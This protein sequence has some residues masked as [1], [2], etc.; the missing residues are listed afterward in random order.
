[1][2]MKIHFIPMFALV[3]SF[4]GFVEAQKSKAELRAEKDFDYYAFG[5]AS[6]KYQAV[7]K[8]SIAGK[9]NLAK[10]FQYKGR[11]NESAEVYKSFIETELA[12]ASDYLDYS[13]VLRTLGKYDEAKLWLEKY[14]LVHPDEIR[15]KKQMDA[16]PLL[17]EFSKDNGRHEIK[18][19]AMN[20]EMQDFGTAFFNNSVVFAS[21]REG[22]KSIRRSY[23]WNEKPFLDLYI[24][25]EKEG[26]LSQ[27]ILFQ[28]QLNRAM[29]EGP[30]AF[31]NGGSFMALTRNN[32][33]DKSED[34][35]VKLKIFFFDLVD[36]KWKNEKAFKY[37]SAAYSVGHPWLSE[38]GKTMFFASDKPGGYG[39]S[40]IYR[41]NR[42]SAGNWGEAYNLGS[43]INTEGDEMFPF[44]HQ[45]E[46]KLIFSSNGHLGLGGLDLFI[47]AIH[48]DTITGV[49]NFASPV[50]SPYDDFA[51]IINKE[52]KK[53]YFSS[54][55][56]NVKGDDDIYSF[57][58]IKPF[59]FTKKLEGK[60]LDPKG[61]I[62][63]GSEVILYDDKGNI[64]AID[65]TDEN[66]N[67]SFEVYPDRNYEL[68]AS[69]VTFQPNRITV[70][71]TGFEPVQKQDINL[72]KNPEFYLQILVKDEKTSQLLPF[73]KVKIRN[74]TNVEEE[75]YISSDQGE[76]RKELMKMQIG[77]T[78]QLELI[79]EKEG[80]P[81][82]KVTYS[83]VLVR[84]GVVTKEILL[85]KELPSIQEASFEVGADLSK[86]I[87]I[88]P[89]F[90][91]LGKWNIRTD[92]AVE[93]DKIVKI[94]NEYP[95]MIVEL[96]SHTDCRS[97]ASFN[98]T[99]SDNRAKSSAEY[100]KK[101]ISTP[102]R[103][104][105]KGYGESKLLNSC[106]CEGNIKSTCS[107]EQHQQNRRTE[108]I[109]IKN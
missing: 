29:H 97:S 81:A 52:F 16:Y 22:V 94:M 69:K 79:V 67:Y 88:K 42:D 72:N 55:R 9:R 70:N 59:V 37:N 63:A 27:P 2:K 66:G 98:K 103:I 74:K 18:L 107:E 40:D 106:A 109:I 5:N 15:A 83:E 61:A 54:N 26:E 25:E 96:G 53:G 51:L 60:S 44:Y 68:A 87:D 50:N 45:G 13:F 99:L 39:G 4:S 35:I 95:N 11:F 36:E 47:A 41:I 75:I 33:E 104:Y 58:L 80:Y 62:L 78:V 64:L 108:F 23:N 32:Y 6:S 102:E 92:A 7:K 38:D 71:T 10:S 12:T 31:S 30:V 24:S 21:S 76:F 89:I 82:R 34:G 57:S 28:K 84:E 49:Q 48:D 20:T 1:M 46:Q 17:N 8:L 77:D 19:L 101:R 105:G 3:F 91:D 85:S 93:L 90:F 65:T 43:K 14:Y 100:I 73:T 56:I 86:L